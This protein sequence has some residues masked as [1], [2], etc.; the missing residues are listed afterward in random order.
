MHSSGSWVAAVVVAVLTGAAGGRA[1][2]PGAERERS[3]AELYQSACLSC[4]G[5][6]GRGQ[7]RS[8]VGF[9]VP[10]PDFTDCRFATP[11]PD[12]D[13]LA[14]THS[15]GPARAFDRRM[16]A[17]GEALTGAEIE[18]VIS[19]VRGFCTDARWPRGDLN[20]PRALVTEKAFPENEAV[21]TTSVTGGDQGSVENEFLYEHRVGPRGQ[22]EVVV[23]FTV[24]QLD[25]GSWTQGLGDIAVAYKHAL[26]HSLSRGSIL[27]AGSEV[28]FP[29]G[30]E[31]EQLGGGATVFEVFGAF[32][33]ILP[34][35]GFLQ[36][37]G[38]FGFPGGD[39]ANEAFWRAAVGKT[40]TEGRWGRTWS[41]MLEVL[42]QREMTE[43]GTTQWALLPEMQVTLSRRQHVMLN[44][45][46]RIPLNERSDR[47][48]T[49]LVYVLW[50]WFDGGL[51][52]GW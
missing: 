7:P 20:L 33:Q 44:G 30:K 10:L 28:V 23:P 34:R 14:V 50:D 32:G 36:L 11:E 29:T 22:Y 4:H 48:A 27:S 6:D 26:F 38:G 31:D 8:M 42:G 17:Y 24:Q 43:D 37:H 41:P 51:F 21:V 9:E 3:G 2:A 46:V 12:A 25:G 45:G 16:P 1:Q 40:F 18:R 49:V 39:E 35:D 15:G 52:E 19:H 47:H 5:S 13:W